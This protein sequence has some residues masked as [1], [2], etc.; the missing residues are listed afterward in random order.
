MVG[1]Q[2]ILP[3]Q[4]CVNGQSFKMPHVNITQRNAGSRRRGV[5]FFYLGGGGANRAQRCTRRRNRCLHSL[6]MCVCRLPGLKACT[7]CVCSWI[8]VVT[9]GLACLATRTHTRKKKR[10]NYWT[11][12]KTE[13]IRVHVHVKVACTCRR[14]RTSCQNVKWL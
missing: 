10:F 8:S 5:C 7:Y 14:A 9:S 6:L 13:Q 2:F 4:P 12:N 3:S 1:C 11:S